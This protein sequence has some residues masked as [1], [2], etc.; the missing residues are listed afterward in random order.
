MPASRTEHQTQPNEHQTWSTDRHK[1]PLTTK[2]LRH[3]PTTTKYS[4]LTTT[5][6]LL[7]TK[8]GIPITRHDPDGT[9]SLQVARYYGL[10]I[11]A[12]IGPDR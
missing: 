5:H 10:T 7:T 6:D 3:A 11:L 12:A 9:K 1:D 4:P 8:Q 2:Q